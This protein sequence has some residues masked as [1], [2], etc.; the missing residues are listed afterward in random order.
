M[1]IPQQSAQTL[2]GL[3]D[4]ARSFEK[5]QPCFRPVFPKTDRKQKPYFFF[6][7]FTT[8]NSTITGK[9]SDGYLPGP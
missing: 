2:A 6:P 5:L 4:P 3:K 9:W 7:F 8:A 1:Q